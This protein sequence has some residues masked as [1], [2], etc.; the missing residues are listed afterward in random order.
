MEK[1]L[2]ALY[3]GTK[4]VESVDAELTLSSVEEERLREGPE[5]ASQPGF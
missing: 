3:G 1:H 4:A 2:V 5:L